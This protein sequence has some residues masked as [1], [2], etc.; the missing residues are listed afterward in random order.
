MTPQENRAVG[1]LVGFAVGGAVGTAMEIEPP[2]SFTPTA[3]MVGGGPFNKTASSRSEF[4]SKPSPL[5]N[6]GPT[7]PLFVVPGGFSN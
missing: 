1:C 5:F 4:G 2:G 7:V 3:Y 6:L